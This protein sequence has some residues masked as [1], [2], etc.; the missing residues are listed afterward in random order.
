[1]KNG[2]ANRE[3]AGFGARALDAPALDARALGARAL[4]F[5]FLAIESPFRHFSR[6]SRTVK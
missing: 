2:Y 5:A 6:L 4:G 1:V 3:T